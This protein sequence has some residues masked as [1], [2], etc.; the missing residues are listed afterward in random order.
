MGSDFFLA[1]YNDGIVGDHF[2]LEVFYFL[3]L[4]ETNFIFAYGLLVLDQDLY[5]T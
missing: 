5:H 1:G 4:L 3:H 2:F